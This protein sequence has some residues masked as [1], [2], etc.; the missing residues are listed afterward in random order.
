VLKTDDGVEEIKKAENHADEMVNLQAELEKDIE[1]SGA[2]EIRDTME[3]NNSESDSAD[4]YAQKVLTKLRESKNAKGKLSKAKKQKPTKSSNDRRVIVNAVASIKATAKYMLEKKLATNLV[5]Y[6]G[7]TSKQLGRSAYWNK[8]VSTEDLKYFEARTTVE[9]ILNIVDME[10]KAAPEFQWIPPRVLSPKQLE[11]KEK[12]EK[13]N[14]EQFAKYG[15]LYKSLLCRK[16]ESDVRETVGRT[17]SDILIKRNQK[18][19][20]EESRIRK[21]KKDGTNTEDTKPRT[22]QPKN[23]TQSAKFLKLEKENE[24]LEIEILQRK[25]ATLKAELKKPKEKK[26]R[27]S[28]DDFNDD[29]SDSLNSVENSD[30]TCSNVTKKAAAFSHIHGE[31]FLNVD[32][33]A[34]GDEVAMLIDDSNVESFQNVYFEETTQV[35]TNASEA[36][37]ALANAYIALL[38]K[39]AKDQQAAIIRNSKA[40]TYS[41]G[42]NS[43]DTEIFLVSLKIAVDTKFNF[44]MY[45]SNYLPLQ[46]IFGVQLDKKYT[47]DQLSKKEAVRSLFLSDLVEATVRAPCSSSSSSLAD[48]QLSSIFK[49]IS[50]YKTFE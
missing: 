10:I 28:S 22:K 20:K 24:A 18:D 32:E 25:N 9:D 27:N 35:T 29:S 44:P 15:A 21:K 33:V 30:S 1:T 50:D 11:E 19:M 39:T 6:T 40:S 8:I 26:K 14:A 49:T 5:Q 42:R 12:R 43:T 38:K 34:Y 7:K 23:R 13:E 17:T 45:K 47:I 2:K 16:N 31:E 37:I 48:I 36:D 4:D 41:R 46:A 3:E